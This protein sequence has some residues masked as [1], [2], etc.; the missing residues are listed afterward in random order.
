MLGVL[1]SCTFCVFNKKRKVFVVEEVSGLDKREL[2]KF[3]ESF[4]I[5]VFQGS[6]NRNSIIV[7]SKGYRY[8]NNIGIVSNFC[9]SIE[10]SIG[11]VYPGSL[12][13]DLS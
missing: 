11:P 4:P 10:I 3:H 9:I 12:A 2:L 1:C 6:L 13:K 7:I 5:L 8:V